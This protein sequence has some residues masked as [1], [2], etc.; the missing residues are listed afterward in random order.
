[1]SVIGCEADRED[2]PRLLDIRGMVRSKLRVG[3]E[4]VELP[5][6]PLPI[7]VEERHVMLVVRIIWCGSLSA[8]KSLNVRTR[9]SASAFV[10]RS[11][12]SNAAV[13][14]IAHA[15][16]AARHW[17]L[18]RRISSLRVGCDSVNVIATSLD[19]A[20]EDEGT[21]AGRR[22][23]YR[24]QCD[25]REL[26]NYTISGAPRYLR[27][28]SSPNGRDAN[29]GSVSKANRARPKGAPYRTPRLACSDPREVHYSFA[30]ISTNAKTVSSKSS[31]CLTVSPKSLHQGP[32]FG[33]PRWEVLV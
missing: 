32:N 24:L 9:W 5:E 2:A 19:H 4:V 22:A 10:F 11:S 3:S 1:M 31:G 14:R 26:G 21:R 16:N 13:T 17:S 18:M 8:S 15:V 29:G 28:G 25:R 33:R 12:W 30:R 27:E 7:E 6:V 20:G 23:D